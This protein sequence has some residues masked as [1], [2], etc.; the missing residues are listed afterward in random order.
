MIFDDSLVKATRP[1]HPWDLAHRAPRKKACAN[2][3]GMSRLFRD[4]RLKIKRA[5]K[6]IEDLKGTILALKESSTV[7]V[8]E[9]SHTGAKELIHTLEFAKY[10]DDIALIVGDAIHN[11]RAALD[12]AWVSMLQTHIPTADFERAKFPVYPTP[13]NLEGAINGININSASNIAIFNL[14]MVDIQPY[15]TGKY[16]GI[17]Y[18]LHKLDITDKHLVLLGLRPRAGINGIV[19]KDD[20]SEIFRGYGVPTESEPPYVIPFGANLQVENEGKLAFDLLLSDTGFYDFLEVTEVL[21]KFLNT[22]EHF[23]Q[24]MENL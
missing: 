18:I 11:L 23:I 16:G 12:F 15:E 22:V 20:H 3:F 21:S 24:L 6:H 19:V 8:H 14:L 17:I 2:L 1:A 13:E 10:A 9:N 7:R 4:A 5:N